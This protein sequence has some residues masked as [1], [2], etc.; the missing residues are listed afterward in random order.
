MVC[1]ISKGVISEVSFMF[2]RVY[3][4]LEMVFGVRGVLRIRFIILL[5]EIEW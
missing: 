2:C 1:E 5:V 4:Y 3:R